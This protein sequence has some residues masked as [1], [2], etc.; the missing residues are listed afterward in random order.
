MFSRTLSLSLYN[1]MDDNLMK[2]VIS[3][4]TTATEYEIHS[5]ANN[6]IIQS[7]GIPD[8][9]CYIIMQIIFIFKI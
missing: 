3:N 8:F 1:M 7:G 2:F 5:Y 6:K 4:L 9:S